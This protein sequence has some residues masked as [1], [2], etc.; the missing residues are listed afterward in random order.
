MINIKQWTKF[1]LKGKTIIGLGAL[2]LVALL[3]MGGAIYYQ[4]MQLAIHELLESTGK[5]IEK[6][7]IEIETFVKGSK[8]DLM[9]ISA[10]PPIQG[11]IRAR[12]NGGID[13]MTGDKT[14]YWYARLEQIF[15]A[16]LAYH[17]EYYQLRYL[18]E[19]GD[20]IVR[21]DLIG[22]TIKITPRNE[23]QN[24]AQYPYFMETMKLKEDE[25]YYS[26]VNLN[27]EHGVIQI[28]HTPVFRIATPVYDMQKRVRGVVVINVLAETMFTNIRTAIGGT[29]KYVINQ[30]GY[31]FVHPDKSREFGFDLG[32]DYRITNVLPEFA[33]EMKS[34]DFNVKYHEEE[35]HIDSF[36]KIFFDPKNKNRYWAIA[37]QIPAVQAFKNIYMHRN[38]MV[39]VG[40]LII[41]LSLAIITWISTRKIV[42]PILKLSE[43]VNK[44]EHG[45][46]SARASEDDR[47][48][49][50]GG[51][52]SSFN[53]MAGTIEKSVT[54]LTILNKVTTAASSSLSAD[55][56]TSNVLDVILE[57][58]LLK[59]EKKGAIFIADETTGTLRLAASRGFSEEQKALD[60]TVPFGDCL[61]GKVAETGE[62]IL[63][64]KCCEDPR[65]TRKYPGITPHGHLVLPLK[66]GEKMLGVL[67]LYLA[68]DTTIF[69]EET[70]LYKSIA[71]ILAVS[72]QNALSFENIKRLKNQ[73]GL[74][75]NS[76]GEG[77]YGLDIEGICTFMN[78][79]AE[80]L[81]GHETGALI[82]SRLHAIT[83]H[84]RPDGSAYPKEECMIYASFIKNVVHHVEDEVFWRK[85]GSSF[86]VEYTS[87]PIR[88]ESGT[89]TGAVVVFSD[90]TKRKRAEEGIRGYA[91]QYQAMLSAAL[92]G[93]WLADEK[94]K[95]LDVNDNY[96][97]MC[98]Y[99]R[100]ELLNLSI[101]DLE[102]IENL[103]DTARHM[104]KI[105]ETGADRFESKHK[106]KDGRVFDVEIS[107][108]F[109]HSQRKFVVFIRDITERK[110]SESITHTRL[111]LNEF[112][113]YHSLGELRQKVLD[114]LELLTGSQIGFFHVIGADQ[115]TL[116]LQSWSTATL[117]NMCKAEV[118]ERHYDIE[119]AGVWT[120]C[121]RQRR[122]VIHN[123]YA[124]LPHRKGLPDGHAPIIRELV[125]PV[126]RGDSIVAILGVGNK[127][128]DYSADDVELVS[129]MADLTYDITERKHAEEALDKNNSLLSAI[130]EAQSRFISA[131]EPHKLFD[132]LLGNLLSITGSEYGF[133]GEIFHDADG[134]PYLKTH[135]ITNIAW[136]EETQKF[137]EENSRKGFEFRNLKSLY[138]TVITTGKMLISNSPFTDPRRGGIPKG[139]PPINALLCLPFFSGEKM[140]GMAGIANRPGGYDEAMAE[141]LQPLITTCG[142]IIEAHRN[143][144]LRKKAEDKISEYAETLEIK[145]DERTSELELAKQTS[146]SAN[147]AKSDFLANMSHELRTPLNAIIGFSEILEDGIAGPIADNQ[148]ELAND[149]STSGKH[150]LSLIN[151]ILDLSKVEAGKMELELGEF[152]L[153]ELINGSL[154]MFKEKA[155]KHNIKIA[156]EVEARIG[157]IVADERKIKQV[158]YNLLSNAFKFT[159][160]GGSVSV[161]ARLVNGN[162]IEIS[163]EDTGIG[164]SSEDQ[165]KLFQPF[166]QID[167]ALSRKVPGTGLGLNLC[168]KFV[169]LHGG[170]IWIESE[171]G[172]GSRFVFVIPEKRPG[173]GYEQESS[174]S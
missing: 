164:I 108:S 131:A 18:D 85:D 168:K 41:V 105:I 55:L 58:H 12:D 150:L 83:H 124:G 36:K 91:E 43:A 148:K 125:V 76:L 52:A 33:E 19:K 136:N 24:K 155:M 174:Y 170:R 37:H 141:Y 135:A 112:A 133:I 6:D 109:W 4:G 81:L 30:D 62:M 87:T 48:D 54:E 103:E 7:S 73:H 88:D 97:R 102:I 49:E 120:D 95:L 35:K 104:R 59:F 153:E 110:R 171:V 1:G 145:V 140:V 115:H 84:T 3:V 57:L 5:N 117:Q 20:E 29:I 144:K 114:E 46:L 67:T 169:E 122:P 151:D 173:G 101:S 93:F 138:G 154:V 134:T 17:P 31:F 126:F 80:R 2:L 161:Q 45:D 86:P 147:R 47:S 121:I 63:S 34:R 99:T 89:A 68:A 98:G 28:P 123:D 16:F 56:M 166:Q 143:E 78:P 92:F 40:F 128:Q 94:G 8:D 65:H 22:K 50:I 119:K 96:C 53:R 72:L 51:L 74:I 25:V 11:I 116:S 32:L 139:H 70:R 15:S 100:E 157:N 142:N 14:E 162:F 21:A 172:K 42:T 149:I 163:V 79:T 132:E 9:V 127:Q 61:C 106:A 159:P 60:A 82:G 69:Q 64:Q 107:T 111:R 23:L 66:A 158:L 146:E 90:I 156:A 160:D 152:N 130:S 129:L 38:T 137:Y 75:L 26:E 165:K 39:A 118:K 113:L 27:R 13:P 44:L 77:I 167:S 10:T 71:D